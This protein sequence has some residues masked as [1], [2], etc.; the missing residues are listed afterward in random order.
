MGILHSCNQGMFSENP[1]LA[2]QC[3]GHDGDS[4][5]HIGCKLL[6]AQRLPT[7][8]LLIR[9]W[10][11]NS[12]GVPTLAWQHPQAQAGI[13]WRLPPGDGAHTW[14]TVVVYKTRLVS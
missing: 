4:G 14:P 5:G 13:A 1:L 7:E 9:N 8:G 10:E 11:A 2:W 3:W 12:P 6:P